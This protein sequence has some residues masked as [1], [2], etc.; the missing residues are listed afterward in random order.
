MRINQVSSYIC[1]AR[2]NPKFISELHCKE[3]LIDYR[4]QQISKVIKQYIESGKTI[5][6]AQ[7]ILDLLPPPSNN[8]LPI[9]IEHIHQVLKED[10]DMSYRKILILSPNQN[11]DQ[12]LILRQQWAIVYLGI[13]KNKKRIINI[14]ESWVSLTDFRRFIW[15]P[16]HTPHSLPKKT[17]QPRISM[18]MALDNFGEVYSCFT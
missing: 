1:K 12:N 13:L 10:H 11:S 3:N 4:Q 5:S 9:R 14:D 15:A 16:K 6:R 8:E 2:R 17:V 7:D 18:I